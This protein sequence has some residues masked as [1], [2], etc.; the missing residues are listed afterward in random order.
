MNAVNVLAVTFT[1]KAAGEMKER[2]QWLLLELQ[3]VND[4]EDEQ[5]D[6]NDS[7]RLDRYGNVMIEEFANGEENIIPRGIERVVLGTFH[8]V[9]GK[10]M[11]YKGEL[12]KDLPS[13]H[14]DMAKAGP[15]YATQETD[16]DDDTSEAPVLIGTPK[17]R[18]YTMPNVDSTRNELF[19]MNQ[20][21]SMQISKIAWSTQWLATGYIM[22][23]LIPSEYSTT[24]Q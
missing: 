13:V 19:V 3:E 5:D 20:P 12:L 8:S 9:C 4:K 10:I 23:R 17:N 11:R 16:D 24:Q 15:I 18:K 1:R 6:D 2:L 14:R 21:I 22:S 7:I